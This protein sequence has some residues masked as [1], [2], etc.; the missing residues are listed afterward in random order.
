V[1]SDAADRPGEDYPLASAHL[2]IARPP[3]DLARAEA[4]WAG[5]L[6]GLQVLE[7]AGP[8]AE[9]QHELVTLGWPGAAW[10]LELVTDPD[11]QTPPAVPDEDLLV[12]YLGKP[13]GPALLQPLVN[14]GGRIVPARNPYWDRWGIPSPTPTATG[15]S[16]ATGLGRERED[17]HRARR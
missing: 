9:Q 7:R 5:G 2:R 12:L 1:P 16:S 17:G 4:F 13:A 6:G 14:A 15:S 11:G 10:H 8:H 3:P